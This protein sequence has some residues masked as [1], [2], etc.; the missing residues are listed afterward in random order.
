MALSIVNARIYT[1]EP[2][3][4]WA[5]SV[6]IRDGVFDGCD[7]VP[8]D[9]DTVLDARGMLIMPSFGD[10]HAHPMLGGFE[11]LGPSISGLGSVEEIV[12]RVR[13]FAAM[14]PDV[15]W[16]VGGSYESSLAPNGEFD[17]RWLDNAVAD[18]PVVLRA[19]D[20]HTIWCNSV[21]LERVGISS[22][23][24]DPELGWIVRRPD[25]TPMGTLRE[26]DAVDLVMTKVPAFSLDD[27][28]RAI[29]IACRELASTGITWVQDAWVD[30]DMVDAY[31]E[32][33]RRG[34]L[35][36]RFNL[37][38]RA[39]PRSWREQLAWF[40]ETREA[41][42]TRERLTCNSI[43]FFADGVIEGATAAL[44]D[45][46][47]GD[48][49][50]HGMPV[51]DWEELRL[52]VAAVDALGFQPHI[53]A[54][55]DEG[56]SES[57]NAI[58]HA[59]SINGVSNHRRPVITHVQLLNPTDIPRFASLG[60]I[61][62][63][64]P[65]WACDDSTQR[66]L[67]TPRLGHERA[68]WQYPMLSL[69]QSGCTLS[70]GSDWPVSSHNPLE[71][72]EVAVTRMVPGD[73]SGSAWIPSE[74]IALTD[75]ISAYTAGNAIQAGLGDVWGRITP[76]LSADFVMLSANVF[77]VTPTDIH[78][79]VVERTWCQGVEVFRRN[80]P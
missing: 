68:S 47:T 52:A 59:Q 35:S 67:T 26:W 39:E 54:I 53:H 31:L 25:G 10:G 76:G 66:E 40:E 73:E 48:P 58:E 50:N 6:R 61:A 20:Y 7:G 44:T 19:N 29:N 1:G 38:L 3:N 79:A 41:I 80:N 55:G 34:S 70:M 72:L 2:H 62:N 37:A 64:Q 11:F 30:P 49:H 69:L 22:E 63:F 27:Q 71:C 78:T 14:N 51:W 21:A 77:E 5:R 16:I 42:G 33:D 13:D 17:A 15:D 56:L 32:A 12:A 36:I 57:L 18:R 60:V 23:T 74:R 28:V 43:K 46:Y 8:L 45:G 24:P 65:L 4:P 75:A 9:G